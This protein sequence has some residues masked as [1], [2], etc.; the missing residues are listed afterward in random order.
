MARVIL[1][2]QE[3]WGV[4]VLLVEHDMGMVMDIS[5]RVVV[6]N[7][8]EVIV[9]GTPAEVRRVIEAC[10]GVEAGVAPRSLFAEMSSGQES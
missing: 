7:F 5:S 10:L 4:T 1:D 3:E 2:G 6:L 8:G 9:S